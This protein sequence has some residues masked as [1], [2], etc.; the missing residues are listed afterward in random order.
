MRDEVCIQA[1]IKWSW[2]CDKVSQKGN[3]AQAPEFQTL[4]ATSLNTIIVR[5]ALKNPGHNSP[6][7]DGTF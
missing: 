7:V 1:E 3:A 4:Y 2:I 6:L 5:P